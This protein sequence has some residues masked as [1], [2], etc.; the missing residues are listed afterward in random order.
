[1]QESLPGWKFVTSPSRK[2]TTNRDAT[3]LS[4]D[5]RSGLNSHEHDTS[6]TNGQTYY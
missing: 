4:Q 1:M 6:E 2:I 3:R 5:V